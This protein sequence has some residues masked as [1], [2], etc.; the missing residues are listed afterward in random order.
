[1]Y[2]I[3]V[4]FEIAAD[5]LEAFRPQ[6]LLQARNSLTEVGCQQFDVCFSPDEPTKCFLYEKYDDRAAFD[7]HLEADYFR[8]FS[9]IVEPWTV[10]K[11]VNA[12]EEAR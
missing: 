9:E 5:H 11:E 10:S 7:L 1:M 4:E 2:V 3:T 12:W 8:E 6:M